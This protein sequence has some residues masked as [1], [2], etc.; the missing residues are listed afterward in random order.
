MTYYLKGIIPQFN[1]KIN[2]D[3]IKCKLLVLNI[4][5][6]CFSALNNQNIFYLL[7][8]NN[9]HIKRINKKICRFVPYVFLPLNILNPK[10]IR[11]KH[12]KEN[13]LCKFSSP[14]VCLNF[15]EQ[16]LVVA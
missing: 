5:T 12:D 8:I 2:T 1:T 13:Y 6:L 3:L 14:K 7:Y 16:N 4:C 11:T 15:V 9:L 10:Q